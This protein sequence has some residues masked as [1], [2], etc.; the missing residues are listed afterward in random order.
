MQSSVV[1]L[2]FP[3]LIIGSTWLSGVVS[4]KRFALNV[5]RVSTTP[6]HSYS[7]KHRTRQYRVAM[8]A[9]VDGVRTTLNN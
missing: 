4:P 8:N 5:K 3:P 6:V 9:A 7:E 1:H 2:R